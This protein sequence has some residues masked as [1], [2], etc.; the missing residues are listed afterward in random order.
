MRA[1]PV[2]EPF[3]I[4]FVCTGNTCRSPLAEAIA[5]RSLASRGWSD[6]EV[7]SAG[8]AAVNGAPASDLAKRAARR[9]GL[10]LAPHRSSQ[11]TPEL[12]AWADLV[13]TMSPGHLARVADAGAAGKA[14][15]LTAFAA[16]DDPA[17]A[18]SAVPDPFGGSDEEYETTFTLL[19]ELVERTLLRLA[20]IL[21]P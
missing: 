7:R 3:R 8:V 12:L 18:L 19:E 4:L 9:H 13:L 10:D 6:V 15:L 16:G 20:P 2:S 11:V 21:A 5:R 14:A 1:D 17:G